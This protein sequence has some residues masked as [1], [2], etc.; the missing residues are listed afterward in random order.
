MSSGRGGGGG[1][2][3]VGNTKRVGAK[4]TGMICNRRSDFPGWRYGPC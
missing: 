1:G 3:V 2:G 4:F